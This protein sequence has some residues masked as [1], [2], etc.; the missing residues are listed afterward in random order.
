MERTF[1]YGASGHG[2][3]VADILMARGDAPLVGFI[4]ARAELRGR[5]VLG[6]P[7]CGDGQWLQEE[8]R[9]GSVAVALGVGRNSARQSVA[10]NCLAWGAKLPVLAHPAASVA[11]SARLGQGT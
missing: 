7:V 9:K 5:T 11:P 2:K 10:A 1:V 4:D 8:A 6:L 3:V